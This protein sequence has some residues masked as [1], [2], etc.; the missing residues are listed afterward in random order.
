MLLLIILLVLLFGGGGGYYPPTG[1][2]AGSNPAAPTLSSATDEFA[3]FQ[4]FQ[5]FLRMEKL[6]EQPAPPAHGVSANGHPGDENYGDT[7]DHDYD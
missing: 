6:Y 3:L 4:R 5:R 1:G 2:P 7:S